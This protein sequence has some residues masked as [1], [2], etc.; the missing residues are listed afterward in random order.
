MKKFFAALFIV[1]GIGAIGILM[2][3]GQK[4]DISL[5]KESIVSVKPVILKD[6]EELTREINTLV[7]NSE[8]EKIP[9]VISFVKEKA[10]DGDLKSKEGIKQAISEGEDKF[11]VHISKEDSERIIDT[12]ST[13]ENMGFSTEMIASKVEDAY[14]KYGEDFTDHLEEVFVEAAENIAEDAAQG[15]VNGIKSK[16]TKLFEQ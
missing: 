12:V 11:D 3:L 13:L 5:P 16:I 7:D 4:K 15:V 14:Q 9:E 1:L 2:L 8:K 10:K 6:T